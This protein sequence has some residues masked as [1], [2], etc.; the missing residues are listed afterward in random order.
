MAS[1]QLLP[2]IARDR[3][4]QFDPSSDSETETSSR[5]TNMISFEV[6]SETLY[7]QSFDSD[8]LDLKHDILSVD[9]IPNDKQRILEKDVEKADCEGRWLS[10][11][12]I[13]TEDKVLLTKT[14]ED[15]VRDCIPLHEIERVLPQKKVYELRQKN[16]GSKHFRSQSNFAFALGEED[17]QNLFSIFTL[18]RGYNS[19]TVYQ[20]ST[21]TE[22]DCNELVQ[23]LDQSRIKAIKKRQKGMSSAL[24]RHL[25]ALRRTY[26]RRQIQY[27]INLLIFINF[28]LNVIQSEMQSNDLQVQHFFD[29][30]DECFTILFTVDVSVNLL[31][32]WFRPFFRVCLPC[33]ART[34]ATPRR[35]ALL[36]AVRMHIFCACIRCVPA[37]MH[38]RVV[39]VC[40]RAL[41]SSPSVTAL[42]FRPH[43]SASPLPPATTRRGCHYAARLSLVRCPLRLRDAVV[44]TRRGCH[45][46]AVPCDYATRLSIPPR[47]SSYKRHPCP[48]SSLPQCCPCLRKRRPCKRGHEAV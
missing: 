6:E 35:V 30:T 13:L 11:R 20:M 37:S 15:F 48:L 23:I 38:P 45:L 40:R 34:H 2:W 32:H 7:E 17:R 18:A 31:A 36:S 26:E 16:L 14:G 42:V 19:G 12:L 47:R 9:E 4:V 8:P 25:T 1:N 46:S 43:P 3:N 5:A 22:L 29:V 44:T 39:C 28:A 27:T 10:R 21:S 24:S 41:L 33:F